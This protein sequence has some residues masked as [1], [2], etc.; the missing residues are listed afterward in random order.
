MRCVLQHL[1]RGTSTLRPEAAGEPKGLPLVTSTQYALR[2]IE[3]HG[4]DV[5]L[6]SVS[7]FLMHVRSAV[8]KGPTDEGKYVIEVDETE[9]K[10]MLD[11][12]EEFLTAAERGCLG[13]SAQDARRSAAK[14]RLVPRA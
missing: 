8:G 14:L 10:S 9:L 5:V 11:G 3:Q 12:I 4:L 13:A 6:M 1:S 7:A 2:A